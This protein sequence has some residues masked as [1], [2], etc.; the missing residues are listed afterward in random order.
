MKTASIALILI[1]A[2]VGMGCSTTTERSRNL[3][4]PSISGETLA[5]Q[6]CSNCHGIDGNSVNQNFPKLAGQQK[7]YLVAQLKQFKSHGRF[8]PPG[9]EYM[10]GLSRSLTDKQIDELATYFSRQKSLADKPGDGKREE[11]GRDI[12]EHGVAVQNIPACSTCHGMDAA[13]HGAFPRLAGQHAD[14]TVKQLNVFQR[15][16]ER[17]E[18]A[19]MKVIAHNLTPDN[20]ANVAAYLATLSTK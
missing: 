18:G 8:D 19:M 1:F 7:E 13:G 4:D 12:F 2:L 16:D 15:T 3:A 20:I 14:Y 5:Q 10:W 9:F 17:P 11:S 6:V